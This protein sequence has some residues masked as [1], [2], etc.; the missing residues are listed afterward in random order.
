MSYCEF[1]KDLVDDHPDKLYHDHD[2]GFPV[3]NDNELFGRLILEINQAG[4]S[5]STILNKA[6]NFRRAF[7][8]YQID[9][10]ANYTVV[11][12]ER[13]LSDKGII[14]NRLKIEAVIYNAGKV[15]E[16]QQDYGSFKNW[17]DQHKMLSLDDWVKLF[18]TQFKF[19]GCKIVE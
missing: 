13:L 19:T 17:L 12:K 6:D 7:E 14:R 11:D 5:W 3:E 1:T 9:K 18:K 16:I 8:D 10:I 2:Y 4:L 15:K